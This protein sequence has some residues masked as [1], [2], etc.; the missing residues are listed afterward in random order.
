VR[1]D[2]VRQLLA[3]DFALDKLAARGIAAEEVEQLL[4]NRHVTVR[5]PRGGADAGKRVLVV[6]ATD[7]GRL[8]TLVIERTLDPAVWLVV[9]GWA[10]TATERNLLARSR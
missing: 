7:G 6:G 2:A 1:G 4:R 10:S 8:L 9:T 5:N 3:T